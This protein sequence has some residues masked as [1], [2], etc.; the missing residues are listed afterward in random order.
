MNTII[1]NV[2]MFSESP[3]IINKDGVTKVLGYFRADEVHK[4]IL[5]GCYKYNIENVKL[6][7]NKKFI[8]VIVEDLETLN[9]TEYSEQ[10]KINIE[11]L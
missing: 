9:N 7:G 8:S 1:C 11:V 3:I 2:N 10:K 4:I 6:S 5:A